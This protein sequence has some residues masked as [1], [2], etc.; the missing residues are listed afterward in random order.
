MI[1]IGK[2]DGRLLRVLAIAV[3][4]LLLLR[5][6]DPSDKG[7]VVVTATESV[8]LTEKRLERL[9]ELAAMGPGRETVLKQ[10]SAELDRVRRAF[11]RPRRP[12]RRRRS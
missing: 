11:C 7:P 12:R 2:L 4:A 6:V 3:P 10:V 8:P 5:F 9:R 1:E